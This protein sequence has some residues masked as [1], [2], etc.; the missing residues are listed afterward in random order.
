ML[1][2][3]KIKKLPKRRAAS[4]SVSPMTRPQSPAATVTSP[5]SNFNTRA[6]STSCGRGRGAQG[7]LPETEVKVKFVDIEEKASSDHRKITRS[8][9]QKG[10]ERDLLP[11]RKRPHLPPRGSSIPSPDQLFLE[12][13]ERTL[14]VRICSR[15]RRAC[16]LWKP[17]FYSATSCAKSQASSGQNKPK[18]D[19]EPCV[20]KSVLGQEPSVQPE[21]KVS[22]QKARGRRGVRQPAGKKSR[23]PVLSSGLAP[24]TP[25]LVQATSLD[26]S[27][28]GQ[29]SE[30]EEMRQA[31][32][33][34]AC[35]DREM[36]RLKRWKKRHLLPRVGKKSS[37]L[38]SQKPPGVKKL[39]RTIKET[40]GWASRG[41]SPGAQDTRAQKLTLD[42]RRFFTTGCE[43]MCH[44]TCTLCH[45][46]V[47]HGL[48]RERRPVTASSGR[49]GA[50]GTHKR[51]PTGAPSLVQEGVSSSGHCPSGSPSEDNDRHLALGRAEQLLLAPPPPPAPIKEEPTAPPAAVTRD[52]EGPCAPSQHRSQ[53]WNRSIAE[54]LCSLAL[55]LSFL[56]SPPFRRFMAQADPDYC[57]PSP[58]AFSDEAVPL[59][60]EVMGEQVRQEMQRAEGSRVHLTMCMAAQEVVT[61]DYVAITAHWGVIQRG[62]CQVVSGRVRKQAVLW[63][64]GLPL[65]STVEN[66]QRELREQVRL[67]LGHGSLRPGFLVS[68]GCPSLEPAVT[69]QGY[70][71]IP[72]FAHCLNSV[73]RNF[74]CHHHSVQIILSTVRAI[75]SHFRGSAEARRL[76]AQLQ[77]RCS[78]PAQ[79]PFWELSDHWVSA[80]HLMEWLVEQ[81]QPLREYD[82]K[83]QLGKAGM[84]LSATFWSLTSS[85]VTLLR[86]FQMVVQEA[87]AP[88]ASLSQVL[89]QLRYLHIFL[90][91]VP[92]HFEGQGGGE[93]GAAVRLAR[94]LALQL[95]T[96]GQLSELFHHEEFV[97]ATLLDPRFKGQLEAILPVG[98]DIDHWMQVLVYKVK[99]IMV[100]E[101]SLPP[102]PFLQSPKAMSVDTTQSGRIAQGPRAKGRGYKDPVQRS[103]SPGCLLLAQREKSLLEQLESVGLLASQRSGASLSTENHL[104]TVIVRKYLRENKPVSAQEDP[105]AYW[106]KRQE[107]W[108]ALARLATIYLSCPATSASSG[109]VLASLGSPTIVENSSPL[110]VATVE[111]LLFLKTNLENFP[112]YTPSPLTLPGGDMAHGEQTREPGPRV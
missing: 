82:E 39:V 38:S 70:T 75:C 67:W 86:P 71:H 29:P 90:E 100:S 105:L 102:S 31:D 56:S 60:H 79:Q 76:L 91:Q 22:K 18:G 17:G 64:R 110:P 52:Q 36:Q 47:K 55:P 26:R 8:G 28:V 35:L 88:K 77:R 111:N 112:N 6:T 23:D 68:S 104:A 62:S 69:S 58:A 50:V 51:M 59:L 48:A 15:K 43:N 37:L 83:H 4:R 41:C 3:E 57:L 97:L 103:S 44:V 19:A 33:L 20:L 32:I 74:L 49:A 65:E 30:G 7:D 24:P 11:R 93:T 98:A 95:S 53:A 108:P 89:P 13:E 34:I 14:D 42:V 96:D 9:S 80:Y 73:V 21:K 81:Q 16:S 101:Y 1:E 78:L 66:R 109:S 61:E 40:E 2:V 94:G 85:L 5:G 106:E 107:V 72:C 46:S 12:E 63:V 27:E 99:E 87:S 25:V 10:N 84:G 54:L 45:T 92:A